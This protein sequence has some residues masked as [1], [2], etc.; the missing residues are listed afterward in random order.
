MHWIGDS[1]VHVQNSFSVAVRYAK[2]CL[3][4]VSV[5]SFWI[6]SK[7]RCTSALHLIAD[8]A[9]QFIIEVPKLCEIN[10][11][12]E[13][14]RMAKEMFELA[15]AQAFSWGMWE[16]LRKEINMTDILI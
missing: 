15:R 3:L 11:L 5:P 8:D 1:I 7:E 12:I 2:A 6:C 9:R 4:C 14:T 13:V 10:R 16:T